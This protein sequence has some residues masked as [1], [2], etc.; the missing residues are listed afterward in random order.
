MKMIKRIS[1]I[2]VALCFV[3]LCPVFESYAAEGTIQFSDPTTKVG[4]EVTVDVKVN[5][6]AGAIGDGFV[7]VAYDTAHLEFVSGV[8]ATG[9]N[10]AVALNATGDGSV[11]ELSYT[12]VFKALQEGAATITVSDYTAYMYSN[13]ALNLSEGTATVTIEPGDGT[14]T[15]TTTSSGPGVEV[16]VGGTTYTIYEDFTDALI[17]EGFSRTEM[18][19]EGAPRKG[20]IQDVSG[21]YMF[22]LVTGSNDPV[23]ALYN[24]TDGSFSFAEQVQLTD[25]FYIFVLNA[26]DGSKLPDYFQ[27]TT[28]TLHGTEFPTWQNMEST[29]YYLVYALSS[30]GNEGFYQ[31]DETDGTYQRYTIPTVTEEEK[32]EGLL[33]RVTDIVDKYL[34]Q[35]LIGVWGV[36]LLMLII[37]IVIATK[38][39]HRNLELDDLYDAEYADEEGDAPTGTKKSREQFLGYKDEDDEEYYDDDEEYDE[40]DDDEEYDDEYDD[41]Y[42]DDDEY[43]EEDEEEE[44]DDFSV[45]FIDL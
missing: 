37:I 39:R 44:K 23:L 8:N 41:E 5:T 35:I 36:F 45:D 12:M 26:G 6:A 13:E 4:E 42:Y 7:N 22:Y 32:P 29:A 40:Y 30:T 2:V 27:Q 21:E 19:F 38:L 17:P 24:D 1:K 28:L 3:M 33:G 11:S 16:E 9:G 14:G 31:Y 25:D 10:G 18:Q 34:I 43:Y 20:L 15:P